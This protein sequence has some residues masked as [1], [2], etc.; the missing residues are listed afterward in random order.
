M[1]FAM[2][3]ADDKKCPAMVIGLDLILGLSSVRLYSFKWS[4]RR[5]VLEGPVVRLN[6]VVYID[7]SH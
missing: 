6:C 5:I 7:R 4:F 2:L 1:S 3:L